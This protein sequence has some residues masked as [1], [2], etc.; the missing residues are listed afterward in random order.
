MSKH[1]DKYPE[2]DGTGDWKTWTAFES[3][4]MAVAARWIRLQ[5]LP[6]CTTRNENLNKEAEQQHKTI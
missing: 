2:F 1:T 4:S 6:C 5:W 3:D